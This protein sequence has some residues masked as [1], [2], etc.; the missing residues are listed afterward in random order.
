MD[1]FSLISVNSADDDE[2]VF[3]VGVK[4]ADSESEEPPFI[5]STDVEQVE[6]AAVSA[7]D[8]F[9]AQTESVKDR[10][11]TAEEV[12]DKSPSKRSEHHDDYGLDDI[13]PMSPLHKLFIV[14]AVIGV[15]LIAVYIIF[16]Q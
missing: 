2:E 12:S 11:A 8:F 4:A 3:V 16:F 6:P 13:E 9:V 1:N 15:V 14:A 5:E 7:D 10:I